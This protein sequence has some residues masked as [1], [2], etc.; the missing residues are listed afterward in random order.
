MI[1][2]SLPHWDLESNKIFPMINLREGPTPLQNIGNILLEKDFQ[3]MKILLR[4]R[5]PPTDETYIK[6]IIKDWK[7]LM[8][9]RRIERKIGTNWEAVE[10]KDLRD[11]DVF[12]SFESDGTPVSG[13]G[14]KVLGSPFI[15]VNENNEEVWTVEVA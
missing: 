1:Y 8:K 5:C 15:T 6:E 14:G 7:E 13:G 11:G 12:R 10:M 3:D 4:D 2:L 9:R